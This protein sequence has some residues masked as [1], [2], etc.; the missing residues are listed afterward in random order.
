MGM[1]STNMKKPE[2]DQFPIHSCD[3][4]APLRVKARKHAFILTS[5]FINAMILLIISSI[6]EG[7]LLLYGTGI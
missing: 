2:G 7:V 4:L 6:C 3:T 1:E 5:P